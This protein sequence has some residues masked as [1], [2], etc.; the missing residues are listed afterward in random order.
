[1]KSPNIYDGMEQKL[2]ALLRQ[3]NL[4]QMEGKFPKVM[5]ESFNEDSLTKIHKL[6]PKLPLIQLFSFKEEAALSVQE[7][8]RL[9]TY[10]SSIGVNINAVDKD[11][12]QEVQLNGFQV[13]LYSINNEMEMKNSLN[14]KANGAFTNNPNLGV[15]LLKQFVK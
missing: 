9:N 8:Q 11:F 13:Y 5:V 2:I 15:E 6:K 12:I 1:M 3:Y 7:Y 14:L 10:A 4:I